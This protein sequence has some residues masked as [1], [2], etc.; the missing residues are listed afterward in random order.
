MARGQKLCANARRNSAFGQPVSAS[1]VK[2]RRDLRATEE[3]MAT[4]QV[5]EQ[6]ELV[7]YRVDNGIAI[8][9]MDDPPANTYTYEMMVQ[10]DRNIL[11]A[12][13]DDSVHV[14]VVRGAGNKFFSAGASIP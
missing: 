10:L 12:R 9:E 1:A 3:H 11:Q 7:H 4:T 6:K 2:F 8:L 13:M 14:I 5:V